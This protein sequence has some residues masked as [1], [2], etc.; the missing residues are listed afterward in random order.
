MRNDYS[1][2]IIINEIAL[3]EAARQVVRN[4][5]VLRL[6]QLTISLSS[7]NGGATVLQPPEVVTMNGRKLCV[8]EM[9]TSS[10]DVVRVLLVDTGAYMYEVRALVEGKHRN[11]S[12]EEIF[13]A[14]QNLVKSLRW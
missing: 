2:S 11:A 12:T 5:G 1:G 7:E 9:L 14:Q 4:D 6:A 8:Y 3:D 10:K 13:S